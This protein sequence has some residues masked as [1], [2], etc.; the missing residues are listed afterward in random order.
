M[1]GLNDNPFAVLTAVAAPAVLTNACSLLALGTGN[2][3]ARVVDRT[4][5]VTSARASLAMDNP[6][7]RLYSHQL[8]ELRIRGNLLLRSLRLFY[9]SLGAFAASALAAVTGSALAS[10]GFQ[11]VSQAIAV[12][13]FTVGL[14][15]VLSLVVGCA[16]MV[17]ET[18][19]AIRSITGEVERSA[20]N[21]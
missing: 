10:Y 19:L 6:E 7:Y 12:L 17:H 9:A 21:G 3:I 11:T 20:G 15:A 8:D 14:G 13:G 16:F 5:V 4:R 1:P 2:R 18:R